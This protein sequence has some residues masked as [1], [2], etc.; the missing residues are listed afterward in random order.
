[1]Q[2][3]ITTGSYTTQAGKK[4]YTM[5]VTAERVEFIGTPKNDQQHQETEFDIYDDE[6]FLDNPEEYEEILF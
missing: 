2:G 3:R 1:M 4:K 6:C 5:Q